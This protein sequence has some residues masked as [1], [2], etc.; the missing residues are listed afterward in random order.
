MI[1]TQIAIEHGK[2]NQ[3]YI[4]AIDGDGRLWFSETDHAN[5]VEFSTPEDDDDVGD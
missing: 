2:S 4:W 3:Q 5:W 1:I